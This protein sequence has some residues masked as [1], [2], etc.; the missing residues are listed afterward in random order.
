MRSIKCIIFIGQYTIYNGYKYIRKTM[1]IHTYISR[2]YHVFP[3]NGSLS[4]L[5]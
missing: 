3:E 5:V 1:N 2:I 4:Y